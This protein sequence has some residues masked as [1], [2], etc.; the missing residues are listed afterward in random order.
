MVWPFLAWRL[1]GLLYKNWAFFS[2]L[3]VSMFWPFFGLETVWATFWKIGL[4]YTSS[5]RP[6]QLPPKALVR[7]YQ[8]SSYEWHLTK[9][10]VIDSNHFWPKWSLL[11]TKS[12]WCSTPSRWPWPWTI[13]S[14]GSARTSMTVNL[15]TRIEPDLVPLWTNLNQAE[16]YQLY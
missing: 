2:H 3:L 13:V 16:L 4:F 11:L 9:I 10:T 7:N 8:R 6:A 15:L 14:S 1:F 12:T 5:G